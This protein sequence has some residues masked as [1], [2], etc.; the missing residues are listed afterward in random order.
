MSQKIGQGMITLAW[1]LV[2]IMLTMGA[3]SFLERQRNP[4]QEITAEYDHD[5]IPEVL[6]KQNRQGHYVADGKIN[7][8]RVTFLLDTGATGISIPQTVAKRLQ[9]KSGYPSQ[10]KTANGSITVHSTNLKTVSLGA[11]NLKAL[12][13][14]I[15]PYMEGNEVLLGMTFMR[16]LELTQKNQTLLLRQVR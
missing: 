12:R 8:Q 11:I 15:N 4:N 9:L 3:N 10:V 6:L 7:G 2:L 13:G 1:I 14:H 16:H 5:R